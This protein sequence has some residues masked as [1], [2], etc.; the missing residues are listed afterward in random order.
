MNAAELKPEIDR[1]IGTGE[2]AQAASLLQELWGQDQTASSASFLVGRYEQ[3]RGKISLT[4]HKLAILR[5]FTVEPMVP[6]LRAAAFAA[7]I[8]LSVRLSEFNAYVQEILD[9]V[10]ALYQFQPDTTILAVQTRDIAPELFRDFAERSPDQV[11]SAV[12][13]VLADF[14]SWLSTFRK[15]S[16]SNLVI[17][18]LEQPVQPARGVFDIQ[19]DPNQGSAIQRVNRGL[20]DFAA[21][22]SGVYIL[23]YDGLMSRYGRLQW[24][25]ERKWLTVRLPISSQHLGHCVEEW[26]RFLHPLTGK[27]AKALV[28]DLDNTLWGG[29]IGE[30]GMAGIRLSNEYPG[31][32]FQ[33]V[34]RALLDLQRRGILLA[35][36]SKNNP[37]DAMEALRSH[38]G[39]LL[40]PEHFA[41]MRI[42]WGEKAQSLREIAEELNIGL[43]SLAFLD[44][45]PI[46]RR[47]VRTL[48]PEVMV[49]DVPHDPAQFARAIREFPAFERLT[50]SAED[51]Q[52]GSY[53]QAQRER[54][55]LQQSITSR[56]DFYRSLNQEVEIAA[57][58]RA[59]LAR[60]AQ[61]TNKTNQ[62]NLTTHRYTEQ[63][64]LELVQAPEW[65]C[66]SLQVKDR[67]GDNGLV[68]VALTHHRDQVYEIVTLLMSCRVIGRTV[69]TAFLSFLADH[70]RQLN[71]TRL[72]GWFLPTK[73]NAPAREFYREH[74]FQ[75]IQQDGDGVL[76]AL[77]LQH[78]SLACPEWVQLHV[79][80]GDKG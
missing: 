43:D 5:S 47:A 46:E 77:D 17:H 68:G 29:V 25:D 54:E 21:E 61:L 58:T 38:P 70:A 37:E 72:E 71:A 18:N 30:D 42:N 8:D 23:D 1:L 60:I 39:M 55:Q 7:G 52:R 27:T 59:N 12:N 11:E 64:I 49:M 9:P 67:F 2:T 73:K 35:I 20:R 24:H 53:Y 50:L 66:F 56:E 36:A 32:A 4:P 51:L 22:H 14:K 44:D 34:Q 26:M 40:K 79:R 62:F 65:F 75:P 19:C 31:A 76:W 6:L 16:R 33:D 48:L 45:N 3:I 69:E 74:G 10:G 15:H 13:R 80:N 41:C 57:L 78:S 63:Q 28:V